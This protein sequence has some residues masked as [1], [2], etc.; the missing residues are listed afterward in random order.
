MVAVTESQLR[1]LYEVQGKTDKQI[2]GEYGV[3][4]TRISQLRKQWGITTR[5]TVFDK[6]VKD[7]TDKLESL[8][9]KVKNVK[10]DD[11][12]ANYDLLLNDLIKIEVRTSSAL[13]RGRQHF[14]LLEQAST[15]VV[16][17][18]IRIKLKNGHFRKLFRRTCD[19]II[20]V[21]YEEGNINYWVMRSSTVTDTIQS[22]GLNI[23]PMVTSKFD[24]CRD[25]WHIII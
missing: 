25:A 20:F 21:G 13:D 5:L 15:G 23:S 14:R 10:K 8:G 19:Y 12:T 17:S 7:V 22:L 24:V 3:D 9:F 16:E 18:D 2:A 11:K 6:G 4:R 1:D